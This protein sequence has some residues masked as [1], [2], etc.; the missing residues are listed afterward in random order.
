[1]HQIFPDLAE[2]ERHGRQVPSFAHW[3]AGLGPLQHAPETRAAVYRLAHQLVQ[4]GLQPDTAAVYRLLAALDRLTVHGM[5]MVVHM[6]YACRLHPQG[7]ELAAADF[8]E[9]PQGHMGTALNMVP[10]YAAYMAL[11]A[12]TGETR[13]WLTGLGFSV[14]AIDALNVLLGNTHAGQAALYDDSEEGQNRLLADFGSQVMS[15]DGLPGVP[16][17]ASVHAGTAGA[18]IGGPCAGLAEMQYPHM[19]QPGEKLVAFLSGCAAECQPGRDRLPHWWRDEDTGMALPIMLAGSRSSAP[20]R[21]PDAVGGWRD[22]VRQLSKCGFDPMEFDGQ[23][24]AAFVTTIWEMEQRLQRRIKE[25]NSGVLEYPLPVPCGV[26]CASDGFGFYGAGDSHSLDLPLPGNPK[27]D[28]ESRRLFNQHATQLFV[29]AEELQQAI[30]LFR[31]HAANGRPAERDNR[32]ASRQPAVPEMPLL[33]QAQEC[34]SPLAALDGFFGDLATANPDLRPRVGA[35]T[36]LLSAFGMRQIPEQLKY[37]SCQPQTEQEAMT[38][39]IIATPGGES[40]VSACLGNQ[41][42][43]NLVIADEADCMSMLNGIRQALIHARRQKE[44]GHPPGWLGWPVVATAHAWEGSPL[45]QT[46][47]DTGFCEAMLAEMGDMARVLFP[48]DYNSMQALLPEIYSARGQIACVVAPAG[49]QPVFLNESQAQQ[50]ARDGAIVL[51]E[52]EGDDPLL[53]VANGSHQL[54]QMLR[55][56]QRLQEAGVAY[57]L[58]YLQEPGRF[59]APRD[60]WEL[61]H[62]ADDALVE[63]LF[64]QRYRLRVVL[65]HMRG[66]VLRGHLWPILHNVEHNFV[67]GYRNR[68]GNF[69]SLDLQFANRAC[70]GNVLAACARLQGVPR[71]ALLTADEAA[72]LAGKGNP[73]VLRP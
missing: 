25:K 9:D 10:A 57:R 23:D 31:N 43:L 21:M 33:Q 11:N 37:R 52:Y 13:G 3:G 58:V 22:F 69:D 41:G 66:E 28:E 42:G 68:G 56:G 72:A 65:T 61:E 29:P 2:L 18:I 53:L 1:M 20:R 45:R 51:D 5:R 39:A 50:L 59:R 15:A 34:A 26:A 62:V 6:A 48:A 14:A 40:A 60:R 24:P 70:W 47:Q 30:A 54:Q 71:T 8:K 35:T 17:D 12:L 7:Q 38:G 27:H 4:A 55:A 46:S 19:P 36:E 64:P 49:P 44:A 63:E 73:G 16:L 67:L 32:L